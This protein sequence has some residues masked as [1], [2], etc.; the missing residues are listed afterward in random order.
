MT[1]LKLPQFTRSSEVT[2]SFDI[3]DKPGGT[4]YDLIIGRDFQQGIGLEIIN[5]DPYFSWHEL[6]IPMVD[7]VYWNYTIPRVIF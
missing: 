6:H 4:R 2:E 7:M 1:G 5:C 3:F